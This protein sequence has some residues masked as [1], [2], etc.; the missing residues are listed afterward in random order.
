LIYF[1]FARGF[2]FRSYASGG[3]SDPIRCS[4]R[5][6][7]SDDMAPSCRFPRFFFLLHLMPTGI[8]LQRSLF[9]GEVSLGLSSPPL[10]GVTCAPYAAPLFHG[11]FELVPTKSW[12]SRCPSA[13]SPEFS[14]NP[15]HSTPSPSHW[16]CM[17]VPAVGL[18]DDADSSVCPFTHFCQV[19]IRGIA[20]PL[21][22]RHRWCLCSKGAV[23]E[24]P[25]SR[26]PFFRRFRRM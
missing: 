18:D 21:L 8:S 19:F 3:L 5:L 23:F 10:T 6:R 11:G 12:R 20:F 26:A 4:L 9:L 14:G 2:H 17:S 22:R 13:G 16:Q 7:R 1:L 15:R 24:F 25:P